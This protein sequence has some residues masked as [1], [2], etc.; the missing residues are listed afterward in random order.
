M[1]RMK[2]SAP[3]SASAQDTPP[4][5][6]STLTSSSPVVSRSWCGSAS[7]QS[8]GSS[9]SSAAVADPELAGAGMGPQATAHRWVPDRVRRRARRRWS[10]SGRG[11][12][13]LTPR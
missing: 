11:R 10:R 1:K 9:P 7:G 2:S 12:G 13:R 4:N 5:G 3:A 8:A 6:S